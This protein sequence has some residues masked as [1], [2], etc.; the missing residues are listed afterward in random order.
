MSRRALFVLAFVL[1]LPAAFVVRAS[2]DEP[3][4]EVWIVDQS[5]TTADGGGTLYIYPGDALAGRDAAS[6]VPEV[7]DLGGDARAFCLAATGS[8]PRRPHMILFNEAHTHAILSYVATGHVLFLDAASRHPVGCIDVGAQA[9][10]AVPSADGTYVIVANQNGKLLQRIATDY[11][12][13]TFT[14]DAAATLDLAACTTPSG[15]ACEDPAARPDN[16]PICPVIDASSRFVF[17]TLRG[18]GLFVV[19]GTATPLAIVA[20]YDRTTIHPNGCGGVETSGKIYINS[21][22]GTAGNPLESDLYALPLSGFDATPNPPNT[23]APTLVFSHDDQGFVDSHG[24]VLAR[25]DRYLWVG[26]RAAN[27]IIVVDTWSDTVVGEISLVG[28]VSADPAP[29]LLDIAPSGNRI[30]AALR[31]PNPLTANAAGVNN[32]VGS[33]PGLGIIRVESGGAR[34][35]FQALAPITHVVDGVERADPHG[36]AVRRV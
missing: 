2:A 18:G 1:V 3:N 4:H 27:R 7:I 24:A 8:A 34:G 13:N 12:T 21:G 20:E 10:S 32:A 36:I 31:G 15:A 23:P 9:H 22:G 28:G 14:L 19:D 35:T 6:A 30:Y 11:G 26:D 16:A 29:D 17:V 25:G 33:T 5:D